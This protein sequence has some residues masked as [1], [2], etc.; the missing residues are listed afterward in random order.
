MDNSLLRSF[1]INKVFAKLFK[2]K[3]SST[4]TIKDYNIN[5]TLTD[6][7]NNGEYLELYLITRDIN[8]LLPNIIN[9]DYLLELTI[10]EKAETSNQ[11]YF[12]SNKG[13]Y[14]V[15]RQPK[16][17]SD[18]FNFIKNKY[19]EAEN[20]VYTSNSDSMGNIMDLN[21]FALVYLL[22][23]FT[24]NGDSCSNNYFISYDG[25]NGKFITMPIMN[26]DWALGGYYNPSAKNISN[27]YN[28]DTN[29]DTSNP[30]GWFARYKRINNGDDT[31]TLN[32]QAQLCQNDKFWSGNVNTLWNDVKT[33][34][35][36]VFG[37]TT[38][39]NTENI[40]QDF[41]NN[42]KSL[43]LNER[44]YVFLKSH[45]I[46]HWG[47]VKT[48]DTIYQAYDYVRHFANARIKWMDD[49]LKQQ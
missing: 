14:V 48:G 17:S 5:Y 38:E 22:Q 1:E 6:L 30:T 24:K 10:R 31:Q 42:I 37:Y 12:K 44:R 19:N 15:I 39:H 16:T 23:E 45:L 8:H 36:N 29:N 25:D 7:Y 18:E 13:Q 46:T 11:P 3:I 2:E 32:L 21:S 34:L 26:Y 35:E 47:S 9:K 27:E 20:A 4:T 40:A 49:R 41:K 43:E 33:E 28:I